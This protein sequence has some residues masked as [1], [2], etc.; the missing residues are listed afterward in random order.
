M[1]TIDLLPHLRTTAQQRRNPWLNVMQEDSRELFM[2]NFYNFA[3]Q[4]KRELQEFGKRVYQFDGQAMQYLTTA[5]GPTID[6]MV[7]S[8]N[9]KSNSLQDSIEKMVEIEDEQADE[10]VQT[11]RRIKDNLQNS[12]MQEL[13]EY[14]KHYQL[15]QQKIN[16][17]STGL[18]VQQVKLRNPYATECE[19]EEFIKSGGDEEQQQLMLMNPISSTQESKNYMNQRHRDILKLEHSLKEVNQLFSDM[20]ILV[21]QQGEVIDRVS[22]QIANIKVQV[23]EGKTTLQEARKMD[24]TCSIQ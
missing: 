4:V 10:F 14:L 5:Q 16:D 15:V 17:R 6:S 21:Q 12:L 3:Q 2:P 18:L 9:L 13:S 22:Y 19:V 8:I 20:A 1:P 7:D 11:K 24:R 23:E